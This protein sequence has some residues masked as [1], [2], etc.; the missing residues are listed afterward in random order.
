MEKLNSF[1]MDLLTRLA[2]VYPD[3]QHHIPVLRVKI[4]EITG[5]GM[6]VNFAYEN[7]SG[8]PKLDDSLL[9]IS[10]N[11]NIE[12]PSLRYGLCCQVEVSGGWLDFVE[13]VT[14]GEQWDGNLDGYSFE[15]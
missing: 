9:A 2:K 11:E 13:I 4:R 6:Y 7:R 10:T 1:E 8:I 5:V 3:L 14:Y 15:P 12:I